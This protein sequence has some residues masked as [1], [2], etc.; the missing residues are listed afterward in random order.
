M[1]AKKR[2][3]AVRNRIAMDRS[4]MITPLLVPGLSRS[5]RS[6]LMRKTAERNG[7]SVRTLQRYVKR[8]REENVDGLKPKATGGRTGHAI[9]DEVLQKAID[10]R[11]ELP[12]RS[13]GDIIYIME[14]NGVTGAGE[15]KRSTL[16]KYLQ[17]AGYGLAQMKRYLPA[18]GGNASGRFQMAHRMKLV[19]ADIKYGPYIYRNGCRS[20]QVYWIGWIDDYSRLV[21]GGKFYERQEER[22]VVESLQETVRKYGLMMSVY[23][24]N[25]SQYIGKHLRAMCRNLGIKLR[26]AL[27]H[28][29]QGKGKIERLNRDV[30]TFS[31]ECNLMKCRSVDEINAYFITWMDKKHQDSSHSSLE[32]GKSPREVFDGDV[33]HPLVPVP[34]RLI[35]EA[36]CVEEQRTV[37]NGCVSVDG[38]VFEIP[39][40]C[41]DGRPVTVRWKY[42]KPDEVTVLKDGVS[43]TAKRQVITENVDYTRRTTTQAELEKRR[44][45]SS[46]S[47]LLMAQRRRFEEEHPGSERFA[48]AAP[49]P[50]DA[51]AF[52]AGTETMPVIRFSVTDKE[53]DR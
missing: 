29:A 16:Q 8:Y 30:E 37:R 15:V 25:G 10:L 13:V 18:A 33:A 3:E 4:L 49:L 46:G 35:D 28:N 44:R 17:E 42:R 22:Y 7:L 43:Y 19:Q 36:P 1:A 40:K 26:H 32:D 34:D 50:D 48:K 47:S 12:S 6:D 52:R 9:S 11:L 51:G 39:A 53:E 14:A 5:D 38:I 27:P 24:D 31:K 45:A 20:R 21:L 2:T 41:L 23:C